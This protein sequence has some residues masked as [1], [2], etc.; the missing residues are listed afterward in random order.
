MKNVVFY[1]YIANHMDTSNPKYAYYFSGTA[2]TGE[3]DELKFTSNIAY[4][5]RYDTLKEAQLVARRFGG[6][7]GQ[8]IGNEWEAD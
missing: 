4:A 8:M 3:A 5:K 2:A 1:I 7:V 6:R